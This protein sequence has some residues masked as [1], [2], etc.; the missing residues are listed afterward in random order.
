[1]SRLIL[2]ENMCLVYLYSRLFSGQT[3]E[4]ANAADIQSPDDKIAGDTIS[5]GVRYSFRL[6]NTEDETKQMV[7]PD[8]LGGLRQMLKKLHCLSIHPSLG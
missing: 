7:R 8:F 6:H 2:R 5:G 4:N 3:Q 1:M